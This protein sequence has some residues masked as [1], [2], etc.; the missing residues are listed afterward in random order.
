MSNEKIR[1]KE[2]QTNK[3]KRERKSLVE[4]YLAWGHRKELSY[5]N[6]KHWS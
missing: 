6:V 5:V 4:M 1:Y 2:Q 3:K